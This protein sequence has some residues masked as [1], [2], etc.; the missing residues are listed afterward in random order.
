MEKCSTNCFYFSQYIHFKCSFSYESGFIIGKG[1]NQ[2][3]LVV[4]VIFNLRGRFFIK[5][6]PRFTLA[7]IIGIYHEASCMYQFIN[8]HFLQNNTNGNYIDHCFS[9]CSYL[10]WQESRQE[11]CLSSFPLIYIHTSLFSTKC[12]AQ[13]LF[14]F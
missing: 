5:S 3:P 11:I 13:I 7:D 1:N 8:T 14:S 12:Q 10:F 6:L 2:G 9:L 4:C